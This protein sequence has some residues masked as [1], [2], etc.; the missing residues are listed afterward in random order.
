MCPELKGE[1]CETAGIEPEKISCVH[2]DC[3]LSG[4]WEECKVYITRRS[5]PAAG[6]IAAAA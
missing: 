5:L 6:K 2:G 3:C 4:N 1:I